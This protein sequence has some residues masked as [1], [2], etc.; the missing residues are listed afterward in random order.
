MRSSVEPTPAPYRHFCP[1]PDLGGWL[2]P[3]ASLLGSRDLESA[4]QEGLWIMLWPVRGPH[5]QPSRPE[6]PRTQVSGGGGERAPWSPGVGLRRPRALSELRSKPRK[7]T[8][9]ADVEVR[10][11]LWTR[12]S[13]SRARE[14]RRALAASRPGQARPVPPLPTPL[15]RGPLCQ[16]PFLEG[17]HL[18][19]WGSWCPSRR[20]GPTCTPSKALSPPALPAP[21]SPGAPDSHHLPLAEAW[22]PWH[23]PGFVP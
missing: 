10:S 13:G 5:P 16:P 20:L 15:L 9:L 4:G 18:H 14:N 8:P 1:C 21:P 6:G 2:R 12:F 11:S 3:R 23:L 17:W 19:V 7:Q 22:F